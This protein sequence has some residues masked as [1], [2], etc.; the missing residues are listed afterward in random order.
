MPEEKEDSRRFRRV[1][2]SFE[3]WAKHRSTKR[4]LENMLSIPSSRIISSLSTPVVSVTVFSAI[5]GCYQT[6][7]ETGALP[8]YLPSLLLSNPQPL[9][10]TSFALS[11]LL[12]FRTNSSY[13]RFDEARKMWGGIL[14]HSR[15]IMQQCVTTFPIGDTT[16]AFALG[17]WV[18][19]FS[20]ALAAAMQ[21]DFPIRQEA[22]KLLSAA[23]L[24]MLMTAQNKPLKTLGV[25]SE[26]V[27]QT[28]MTPF[29]R[30]KFQDEV[31]FFHDAM[32]GC[33]RILK[34]PI[35]LSY[36]RHTCRFLIVWL[37][38]LP[39]GLW[40]DLRWSMVPITAIVALLL[41]GIEE[42]GV[43]IEEPFGLLP[44]DAICE[45]IKIDVRDVLESSGSVRKIVSQLR[46]ADLAE[47]S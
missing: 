44:L 43:Q 20:Y 2:Y 12:V 32:G 1:V 11:L 25:V 19:A 30:Q 3:R 41:L 13:S 17:R 35:P 16:A 46:S 10:L 24:D 26:L 36:T 37:T 4:Y 14:N 9:G 45:R 23:E 22:S 21:E 38:A 42:I 7:L 29:Q 40:H 27:V 8:S 31:T 18:V 33:E 6:A 47:F 15:N 34:T 5:V 39:L 28:D